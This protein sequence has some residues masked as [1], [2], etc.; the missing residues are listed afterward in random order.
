[1]GQVQRHGDMA[2]TTVHPNHARTSCQRIGQCIQ[3]QT[4]PDHGTGQFGGQCFAALLFG[5]RAM[6]QG[7]HIA[8]GLQTRPQCQPVRDWPL[9]VCA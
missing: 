4:W 1:M 8:C 7:Q 2:Q 5:I 9:L 6:Q 3:T